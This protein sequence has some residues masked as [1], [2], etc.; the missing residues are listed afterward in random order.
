MA[1]IREVD[2]APR[3]K[4]PRFYKSWTCEVAVPDVEAVCTKWEGAG[5]PEDAEEAKQG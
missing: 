5:S 3:S 2:P 1:E 4:N